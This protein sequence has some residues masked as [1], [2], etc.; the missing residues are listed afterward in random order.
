MA[1]VNDRLEAASLVPILR[2]V[3][4]I[5]GRQPC[6]GTPEEVVATHSLAF[7]DNN[8]SSN[9]IGVSVSAGSPRK[10]FDNY[11]SFVVGDKEK[12]RSS[13]SGSGKEEA[14]DKKSGVLEM[15]G[16][17]WG[18]VGESQSQSQSLMGSMAVTLLCLMVGV[19]GLRR[20]G[21]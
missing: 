2:A 16:W 18:M 3:R 14:L 19:G 12:V 7:L 6:D 1:S 15:K 10:G 11:H 17:L 8:N 4:P 9:N 13:D 5:P 21:L 20:K